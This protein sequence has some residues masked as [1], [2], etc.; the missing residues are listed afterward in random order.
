M[1]TALK[2]SLSIRLASLIQE[3]R[4]KRVHWGH[5]GEFDNAFGLNRPAVSLRLVDLRGFDS[6]DVVLLEIR[7]RQQSD[8][9]TYN[10][11]ITYKSVDFPEI[12]T[13]MDAVIQATTPR[14]LCKT[15][16]TDVLDA[17]D[18]ASAG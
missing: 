4:S 5:D 18:A 14:D 6:K 15:S 1:D 12:S 7:Y 17:L 13:L 8:M 10:R 3:T 16:F 11:N 2:A 9:G